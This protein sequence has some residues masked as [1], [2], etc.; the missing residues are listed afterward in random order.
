[1]NQ[2]TVAGLLSL[3]VLTFFSSAVA[4]LWSVLGVSDELLTLLVFSVA[5]LR[6]RL[7]AVDIRIL[8]VLV[9]LWIYAFLSSIFS[10]YYQGFAL[11]ALDL[12]LL[13]KPILIYIGMMNLPSRVLASTARWILPIAYLYLMAATV[14]YFVNIFIPT[15]PSTDHRFGFA[16]YPFIADNEGEFAN[17]VLLAGL[18][19]YALTQSRK[20]RLA[21][22]VL[23]SFLSL[24]SLRV[25]AI[26]V[27]AIFLLMLT[28]RRFGVFQRRVIEDAFGSTFA[29]TR[30]RFLFLLALVP[31]GLILGANQ[32]SKYFLEDVTPR[33][34]LATSSLKVAGDFFPF[35]AGAG[36]FGSAVSK[37]QYSNLYHDLG[38]SRLWGLS[39]SD[40]RFLS[41]SFWPMILGQ[42]GL[43]GMVLVL[44]IFTLIVRNILYRWSTSDYRSIAAISL[45]L[46]IALSTLG[47]AALVGALGA[48]YIVTMVL[49]VRES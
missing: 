16:S 15:F 33:L 37:I 14:F 22:V 39:E 28:L 2:L 3:L 23:M 47:S 31:V 46:N 27:V 34:L 18:V 40:N 42:Y 11:T 10:P 24:A 29:F 21:T 26:V 48:L 5:L 44:I 41:D 19:L 17:Q 6:W 4:P 9:I 32:F 1:M 36:T 49:L 38:F 25:K 20:T 7:R 35:G 12:F 8:I 43:F 45:L 30:V 13:S